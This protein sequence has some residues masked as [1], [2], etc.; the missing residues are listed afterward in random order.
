MKTALFIVFLVLAS[1]AISFAQQYSTVRG[2]LIS[3]QGAVAYASVILKNADDSSIVKTALSDSLGRYR[4]INISSGMHFVEA[5]SMGYVPYSSKAFRV[6]GADVDVIKISMIKEAKMIDEVRVKALRPIIEIQADKTVFNV[7]NTLNA[8]G[9]DAFDL[10]RKAPGVVIDNNNVISLEGKAGVQIFIDG[11][12]SVLSGDD[13]V[14]F[15]RSLQATDVDAVELITQPSSKYDAAGTAGI[16]NIKLKRNKNLGTNGSFGLGYSYG[17]HH[18]SNSSLSLNHRNKKINVYSNFSTNLGK[19]WSF[20]D[21]NRLQEGVRYISETDNTRSVNGYN[22]KI[23]VDWFAGKNAVIGFLTNANYFNSGSDGNSITEIVP[24]GD[25]FNF[26]VLSANN[27]NE[28]RNYQV[29]ANV[30]YRYSDPE[31]REFNIDLD[32]GIFDRKS[33]AYQPNQYIDGPSGSEIYSNN[34][35]MVTPTQIAVNTAKMDY[36]QKIGKATFAVGLKYSLVS[37]DNTF[38]FYDVLTQDVLN[39][40]RSNQFLY[41]ENVNAA[42]ANYATSLKQ[43]WKLQVG[44]RLEQ[45]ISRGELISTQ[46]SDDKLVKRNYT[47][48]FPSGGLTYQAGRNHTWAFTAGRRIQRPNYQSL[49]PF[50]SQTSELS[51]RKGNPFLQP[52]YTY[53]LRL[54]HTFKYRFTTGIAYSNTTDFFAQVTDTLGSTKS[55]LQPR[56]VANQE[57]YSITTSLPFNITKWWSIFANTN[58]FYTTF[59]AA[60]EKFQAVDQFTAGFYAQS[61][62]ILPL[63]FKLEL[64]GWG[65]TPSIWGGTYR[66]KSMGA[67]NIAAEKKIAKKNLS[68]RLN[69]SDIFF[70]SPWR[71]DLVYGDLAINGT[72]GWESRSFNISLNYNFGNS[73][74]KASRNRKTGLEEEQQRTQ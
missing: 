9:S 6:E 48:L 66:T 54:S 70:T 12:P 33:E 72:G 16:I 60:D 43:K 8:S 36:S 34:Y 25:P 57:S 38:D 55:F 47:N 69:F 19:R 10:L 52:Q 42:Y 40:D 1:S 67:M 59:S 50:E 56:N 18:R 37:T 41:N 24:V 53:N 21:L 22:T 28:G 2:E 44:L 46:E 51:Y 31:G 20:I 17:V 65:R 45:T 26:Q 39:T 73:D 63:G 7:E 62:F 58:I 71:A 5:Y 32:R 35:R 23:G 49:N 13:L 68:V 3:Q 74:V 29:T 30:N 4:F 27:V 64:S 11:K 14:N 15:L 61:S